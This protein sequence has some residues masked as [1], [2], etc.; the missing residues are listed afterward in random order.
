ML[1]WETAWIY[2]VLLHQHPFKFYFCGRFQYLIPLVSEANSWGMGTMAWRGNV[3]QGTAFPFIFI[4]DQIW[5]GST[6]FKRKWFVLLIRL[7]TYSYFDLTLALPTAFSS[8]C[9]GFMVCWLTDMHLLHYLKNLIASQQSF[10][11]YKMNG[12]SICFYI[13]IYNTKALLLLI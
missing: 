2:G 13:P 9:C 5:G 8:Q 6:T 4:Y 10:C 12:I 3:P 1:D 11:R 7:F